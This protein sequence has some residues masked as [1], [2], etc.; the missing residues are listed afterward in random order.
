MNSEELKILQDYIVNWLKP[1]NAGYI[2]F[3][4]N[5]GRIGFKA[6]D[7]ERLVI[8]LNNKFHIH[9]DF[10]TVENT[11]IVSE[12]I[13]GIYGSLSSKELNNLKTYNR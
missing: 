12:L 2:D 4:H 10:K 5:F 7:M 6:S 9:V 1:Y 8:D 11:K 3:K 13:D